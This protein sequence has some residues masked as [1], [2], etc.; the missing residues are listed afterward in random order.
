MLPRVSIKGLL[1]AGVHFGHSSSKWD[2]RM[3]PYLHTKR[4]GIHIID[5]QKT[6]KLIVKA[7][8]SM[9]RVS[10]KGANILFISTKKQASDIIKENAETSGC[11]YIN[12]RWLGGTLTNYKTIR[13]RIAYLKKLERMVE[14]GDMDL[15]GKKERS[16]R[17]KELDKL[18]R[19]LN[20]IRDMEKLPEIVFIVDPNRE[21]IAVDE[22]N[23]L[24]IPIVAITDSNCN[25]EKIQYVIPGNDDAMRAIKLITSYISEAIMDGKEQRKAKQDKESSK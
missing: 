10:R 1:E 14:N 23:K 13:Q 6:V 2:P 8:S 18:T 20:G 4:N 5:L 25:P 21:H 15:L 3:S 22:C 24:G 11:F 16:K 7:C 19:N 17:M 12:S 9:K